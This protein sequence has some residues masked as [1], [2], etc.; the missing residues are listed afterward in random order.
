M[1]R[2][3]SRRVVTRSRYFNTFTAGK[4]VDVHTEESTLA[5][6]RVIDRG[7]KKGTEVELFLPNG[8]KN[9]RISMSGRQAK[10]IVSTLLRHYERTGTLV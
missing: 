4:S 10:S 9:V 7:N 8:T 3:S 2:K 5:G 1:A 6:V